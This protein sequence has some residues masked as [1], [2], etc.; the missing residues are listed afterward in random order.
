MKRKK[1][2]R[3]D[4][5]SRFLRLIL[6]CL[7]LILLIQG[8][9]AAPVYADDDRS[10]YFPRVQ[11]EAEIHPDGS[12]SVAEER[13]F[14]FD[15][16]Y[17]GVFQHIYLK[18]KASIKDVVISEKGKAYE[19]VTPDTPGRPGIYFV[20]ERADRIFVDWSFEAL[21]EERTFVLSYTVENAVLVH[22]DV[23]ELYYQFIGDE[24]DVRTDHARVDLILP[25]G[26]LQ[27]DLRMWGHGPLYG[28]VSEKDGR[29]TWEVEDL[30]RRTFL[31]GR[32]TFPVELVPRSTNRS[33]EKGLPGIL[34]EEEKWAAQANQRRRLARSDLFIGGFILLAAAAFCLWLRRKALYHPQ[35]YQGDYYR[36]LPGEYSPAEAGYFIRS[37][38]TAPEDIT[39]TLLDLSRRGHVR[40]EEF[41]DEKGLLIKRSQTDYRIYPG[42]GRDELAGHERKL[43]NF[44]FKQ[45]GRTSSEGVTFKEIEKYAK[46]RKESTASFFK[47]WNAQLLA[48][49][50]RLDLFG[51]KTWTG[52]IIGLALCLAGYFFSKLGFMP[53]TTFL[54]PAGGVVLIMFTLFLEKLTPAGADHRAKWKAFKRFL[55]HFSEMER[56]TIPALE[57]WEHY[58]VYAVTLGVAKQVIKQLQVVYP[59]L[60]DQAH[61]AASPYMYMVMSNP[62][63]FDSLTSSMQQS[64]RVARSSSSSGSGGGGGF[65]G[66][67]G[68]GGGGGGIGAR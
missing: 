21:N 60:H 19:K 51:P 18:D 31:E 23:A 15:G 16:R 11:I 32:V 26:A 61:L 6:L 62:A 54:A 7:G 45:V 40:L 50:N 34:A 10:F 44:I 53:F 48:Q 30:P 2:G 24:S 58:L 39:A 28:H 4:C 47:G 59:Q 29:I 56:S 64:F 13:T 35:A 3:N 8:R 36:E 22:E 25:K 66:G 65:S 17:E 46:R 49:V 41:Q 37:R 14:S 52:F 43:Y 68:G 1:D 38:R 9:L 27:D 57:I 12:M 33:G 5:C 67:G 55:L 42:E 63:S 20:E